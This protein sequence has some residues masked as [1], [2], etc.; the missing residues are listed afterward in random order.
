MTGRR[1]RSSSRSM[2]TLSPLFTPSMSWVSSSNADSIIT[3]LCIETRAGTRVLPECCGLVVKVLLQSGRLGR[4]DELIAA[5]VHSDDVAGFFGVVLDL[6]PQLGY[7]HVNGARIWSRL[8]APD[9]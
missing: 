9:F 6:L 7:M 1:C 4:R 8:V 3:G 5:S 2:H